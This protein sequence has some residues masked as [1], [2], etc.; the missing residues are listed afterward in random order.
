MLF[1]LLSV[2]DSFLQTPKIFLLIK[3][4]TQNCPTYVHQAQINL[5]QLPQKRLI[6]NEPIYGIKDKGP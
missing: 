6:V 1:G 4:S 2:A 5:Y 3:I